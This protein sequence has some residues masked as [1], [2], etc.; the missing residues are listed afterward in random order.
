MLRDRDMAAQLGV[1]QAAANAVDLRIVQ[2][3]L[4]PAASRF[5][6]GKPQAGP[7]MRRTRRCSSAPS[8]VSSLPLKPRSNSM[9]PNPASSFLMAWLTA[10]CVIPTRSAAWQ[11]PAGVAHRIEQHQPPQT[12]G[13]DAHHH[14]PKSRIQNNKLNLDLCCRQH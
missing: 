3:G 12:H 1:G 8:L 6:D 5:D 11:I 7:S 10:G 13:V 9:A 14:L 4:Q 2:P